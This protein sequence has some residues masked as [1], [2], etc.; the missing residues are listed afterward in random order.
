[1]VRGDLVLVASALILG[2]QNTYLKTVVARISPYKIVFTQM[3]LCLLPYFAYSVGG[4]GLLQARPTAAVLGALAYMSILV[5]AFSFTV[6][7]IILRR[8]PV[9][10]L[11]VFAFSTPLWGVVLSHVFLGEPLSWALLLG[12]ALVAGGITIAV[13]S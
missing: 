2:F 1:M 10:K 5:G 12:M 4:E 6:W 3:A 7:A 11:S 13:R 9:S 8:T